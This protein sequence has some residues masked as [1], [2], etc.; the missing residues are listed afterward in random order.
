MYKDNAAGMEKNSA[1][2]MVDRVGLKI[3]ERQL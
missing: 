1:D 3:T 2:L